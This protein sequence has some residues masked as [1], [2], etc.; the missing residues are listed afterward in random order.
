VRLGHDARA[1]R[2]TIDESYVPKG[3][4][5]AKAA[6]LASASRHARTAIEDEVKADAWLSLLNHDPSF[7][8]LHVRRAQGHRREIPLGE[9]LKEAT[10][11]EHIQTGLLV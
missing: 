7:R 6:D 9:S 4:A 5:R 11:V 2:A 8:V 1:P 3:V 10:S